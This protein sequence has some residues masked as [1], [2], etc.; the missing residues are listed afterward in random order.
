[1]QFSL[2]NDIN[3][4]TSS[5]RFTVVLVADPLVRIALKQL[6]RGASE[7]IVVGEASADQAVALVRQLAPDIA[8][9]DAHGVSSGLPEFLR[10][11]RTASPKIRPIVLSED[12]FGDG[13][14]LV[15]DAGGWGYLPREVSEQQ[16]IRAVR[17][18]THGKVVLDC[19][20]AHEQFAQLGQLKTPA[21]ASFALPLSQKETSVM[22]AMAEGQTDIQI[23]KGL[24]L[25]V[26][27]IK[28]HV[29]SILRKTSTRNRAAAIA[30]AFRSGVLR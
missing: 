4:E 19:T 3:R 1:M 22:R 9:I 2:E 10:S 20:L 6:L 8:L 18:V 27:T 21:A 7:V 26:P 30:T 24:G 14:L 12:D 11:L 5:A 29:R 13:A 28:T 15:A 25:S 17:F 23:A 16:L